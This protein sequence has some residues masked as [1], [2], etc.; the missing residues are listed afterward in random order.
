MKPILIYGEHKDGQLKK[1]TL[2]L[3]S[4]VVRANHAA[5]VFIAGTEENLKKVVPDLQSSGAKKIFTAQHPELN[6]YNNESYGTLFFKIIQDV[7]PSIVFLGSTAQGK[8]LAPRLAAD[9]KTGLASDCIQVRIEGEE[10]SVTRA[11]YSGKAWVDVEFCGAQPYIATVRPN[12]FRVQPDQATAPAEIVPVDVGS[13][14]TRTKTIERTQAQTTKL[15]VTEANI[16]ISGGRSLKSSEN[17][18]IL[19]ALAAELPSAAVGASRAAVDAGY[20]PHRDQVGQTGKVVSPSLYIACGISGAIQHLAGMR[21]SKIIV[22]I[23]K[24]AE[25]PIFQNADYGIVGDL[26]EVIP[27]LTQEIKKQLNS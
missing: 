27:Q 11:L 23:N 13:L 18:S 1:V 9:C 12:T 22:A 10:L 15:D 2:E 5:Y 16:V 7:Q 24:D 6:F 4:E 26:F 17:F 8:D 3:I 19:E 21:G 20:R 14:P 25:A